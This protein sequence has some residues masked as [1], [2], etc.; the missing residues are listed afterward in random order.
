[1]GER[2]LA[3]K[4]SEKDQSSAKAI[5]EMSKKLVGL[6]R[7]LT[8]T[9]QTLK[10]AQEREENLQEKNRNAVQLQATL[11]AQIQNLTR[12]LSES[13]KALQV[14]LRVR[15]LSQAV[16]RRCVRKHDHVRV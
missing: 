10:E 8:R 3:Q 11:E 5:E 2:L 12:Q 15:T 6:E 9:R 13:T 16:K 1:M 14:C 7:E 4:S